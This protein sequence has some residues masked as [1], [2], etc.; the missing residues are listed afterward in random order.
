M[1]VEERMLAKCWVDTWK[2]AGPLLE[3]VREDEIRDSVTADGFHV[4]DGFVK[5][6]LISH[7]PEPWSGLVEQQRWFK[8]WPRA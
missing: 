4:F 5:A 1:T 8:K 3:Q 2:A 6:A 7:P